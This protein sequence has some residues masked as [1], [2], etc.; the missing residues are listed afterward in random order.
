MS[1]ASIAGLNVYPVKSCGGIPLSRARV[2]VRGLE[3]DTA[4]QPVGDR[5]WM[6][7]DSA[8]RFVTQREIP[9]LALVRVAVDDGVL[10]LSLRGTPPLD[11]P[12]ARS[13]GPTREVVVWSS[14][15]RAH[16]GGDAAAAW[17][18]G[19]VCHDRRLGRLGPSQ[20][21]G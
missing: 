7:V 10:R 6:I 20:A 14:T 9:G 12:L 17:L 5:E 2:G 15:V 18:A 13:E 4:Q 3:M 1:A 11:V 8:G 21:A 19:A 16:N